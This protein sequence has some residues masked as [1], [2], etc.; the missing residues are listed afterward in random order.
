MAEDIKETASKNPQE[1]LITLLKKNNELLG[2]I[3]KLQKKEHR[4]QIWRTIFQIFITLLP[5]I[6]VLLVVWY[7]FSLVNQNIQALQSN[8]DALKDFMIG[9]IPD[10]SGVGEKLNDVW[11]D[12][13][14]WE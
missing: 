7:L 1:E 9:L 13:K 4:A 3:L 5:F 6:I 10:F 8:V 2:K 11:Q 12:V 14:F